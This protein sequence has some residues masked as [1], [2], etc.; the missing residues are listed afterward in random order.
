MNTSDKYIKIVN[1]ADNFLFKSVNFYYP[2]LLWTIKAENLDR[3]K[4]EDVPFD[5]DLGLNSVMISNLIKLDIPRETVPTSVMHFPRGSILWS[6]RRRFVL[7]TP[8]EIKK[9][10]EEF[11][12]DLL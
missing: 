5:F 1:Y 3:L 7:A 8:E 4:I 12:V 6:F 10:T 9:F 11:F 2:N